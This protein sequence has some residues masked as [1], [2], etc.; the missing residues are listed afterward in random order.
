MTLETALAWSIGRSM[1]VTTVALP[2]SLVVWRLISASAQSRRIQRLVII[3]ALAPLFV[4]DLLTGFT[5]RMTSARLIHSEVATEALYAALL[6]FRILALQVAVRMMLPSSSVS[7]QALYSWKLVRDGSMSWWM[8]WLRFQVQGPLR[9]PLIAWIGGALFCFQEFETAAL[10]Q[11]DRHPITWSVW[12]FDAHAAG[13]P[14]ARSLLFASESMVFQVLLLLPIIL[15]LSRGGGQ[16]ST[17]TSPVS[18]SKNGPAARM[19][20][21]CIL[22]AA[23]GTFVIW[24]LCANGAE[25][26]AGLRAIAGQGDLTQRIRLFLTGRS[27]LALRFQQIVYS[28]L[29][30]TIASVAALQLAIGVRALG[31]RW[32][33]VLAVVPGLCGSLVVS[34]T[35]LAVFQ[36][37][38]LNTVYDSWLP[39]IVASTLLMLPRALLLV[40]LLEVLSPPTSIHSAVLLRAAGGVAAAH[41]RNLIWQLVRVRWLIATAVLAHWS[42]WDVAVASTLRPVRF[43]P[44]VVRLYNE[45]HYRGTETL[46][47]ITLLALAVPAGLL[48]IVSIIWKQL[49]QRDS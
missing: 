24:P 2:V 19:S 16:T 26:L 42:F 14:L 8:S 25:A 5:Y 9:T 10:L 1:L 21:M 34:L 39:M 37:P 7:A 28:T 44:I 27:D 18:A 15:L 49:P 12:L 13:E 41:G 32:L 46:V 23:L 4:P 11:I 43:E 17:G 6:L 36:T 31:R 3:I 47:A 38:W 35:L 48:C 22:T 20:A 29:P 30:A 33:T 40:V 45:M